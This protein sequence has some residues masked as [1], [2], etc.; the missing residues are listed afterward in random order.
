METG[1]FKTGDV[2]DLLVGGTVLFGV[3]DGAFTQGPTNDALAT[4][5]FYTAAAGG[6]AVGSLTSNGKADVVVSVPGFVSIFYG[7]GDGTFATGPSY[8]AGPDFMQVTI[9]DIDGDGNPDVFWEIAREVSTPKA[10]TT[11]LFRCSRF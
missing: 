3:G 4:D 10:D 1:I 2:K 11:H 5:N 7:N 8:A 6:N 9:T